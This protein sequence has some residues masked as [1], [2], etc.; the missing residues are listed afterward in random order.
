MIKEIDSA[1][2]Q[3][4]SVTTQKEYC[5][6]FRKDLSQMQ[7][8]DP[9]GTGTV[10]AVN[11][12]SPEMNLVDRIYRMRDIKIEREGLPIILPEDEYKK[13]AKEGTFP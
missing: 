9:L 13:H 1:I 6:F 4:K 8:Q 11:I 12:N 5:D 10:Y 2:L 7:K 3:S